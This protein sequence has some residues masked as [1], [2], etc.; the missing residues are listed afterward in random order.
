MKTQDKNKTHIRISDAD[1]RY[2]YIDLQQSAPDIARRVRCSKRTILLRLR[3]YQIPV[4]SGKTAH[5]IQSYLSK[6][7][8]TIPEQ[9]L[10]EKYIGEQLGM[11]GIAILYNCST[12]CVRNNLR[13]FGIPI[14]TNKEAQATPSCV[15]GRDKVIALGRTLEA[16]YYR[17]KLM[18]E[19]YA[20]PIE[21]ARIGS[22]MHKY[23]EDHPDF[24]ARQTRLLGEA[25]L[26]P[27]VRRRQIENAKLSWTPERRAKQAERSRAL[28]QNLE[29]RAKRITTQK[30]QW[31]AN[32]FE[33]LKKM[34][35][36]N[37]TSPNKP[38]TSVLNIL[39]ELY[40]NEWK[41]TG[42]GQVIID[43][44]NP[45]FIN[46]NGKK[47]IIEVFGDYWHRQNVKPYRVNEGR[48]DVY[49]QFGYKTLIIWERETKNKELLKQKIQEFAG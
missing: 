17:R 5:N 42:D 4:R 40:P 8:K 45:D 38:E 34:M 3:K 13:R 48:V 27:E 28:W 32:N 46:T 15:A 18:N 10:R 23:H 31:R 30:E 16:R 47:L 43:G 39:N 21:R 35:L 12:R 36:A 6:F 29:F 25:R 22:I 2:W 14:R 1:L 41:F 37:C 49:A 20:D 9:E 19:R 7:E 44:L 33:V 24:S 11:R 26:N